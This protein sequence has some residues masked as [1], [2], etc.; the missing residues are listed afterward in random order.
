MNIYDPAFVKKLFN[1]MSS[2]YERMNYITSFGFSIRW[3]KQFINVLAEN[4]DPIQVID[5]LSGLGEN[6]NLLL[7][8]YPNATFYALDFS[9]EMQRKAKAKGDKL[10]SGKLKTFTEDVLNNSLPANSF[11]I[12]TC[13]YGLKTFNKDQLNQLALEVSRILKPGGK[14]SFVEVSKPS[15]PVLNFFY[16]FYL[17]KLIPILG[18]LFLGNPSDYRMLWIYSKNFGDCKFV[19]EI[20]LHHGLEVNLNNYFYGCASGISGTK[21]YSQIFPELSA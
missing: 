18:K 6:W 13:A 10:F 21:K 1:Q 20:F 9:E 8:K 14:F 7:K 17:G 11:D 19:Q 16:G 2:S 15:N 3:R 5:I 12:L 4:N